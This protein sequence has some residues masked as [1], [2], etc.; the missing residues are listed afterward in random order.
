MRTLGLLSVFLLIS[1]WG[2]VYGKTTNYDNNKEIENKVSTQIVI[3]DT[4]RTSLLN[5]TYSVLFNS[6]YDSIM[7]DYALRDAY[8]VAKPKLHKKR[9]RKSYEI[10]PDSSS[11]I[12][13]DLLAGDIFNDGG[14][15]L[16]LNRSLDE[17]N[18]SFELFRV[19]GNKLE[20]IVSHKLEYYQ[21]YFDYRYQIKDVNRDGKKDLLIYWLYSTCI[22]RD[23]CTV[24]LKM[25][26][27]STFSEKHEF[28]NPTFSFKEGVV[29]CYQHY[30]IEGGM[31]Y[32]YI[33]NGFEPN[34]VEY[35]YTDFENKGLYIRSDKAFSNYKDVKGES[36]KSLPKEYKRGKYYK[37][38]INNGTY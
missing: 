28:I 31:L 34:P 5:R 26:D 17:A 18:I 9:F 12:E 33:W 38:F 35:I 29:K 8:L 10:S 24:Y 16:L 11:Y 13:I 14:K 23:M 4:D 36:L 6:N 3:Y 2:Y 1:F 32:K 21:D 37:Q 22:D 27:I 7:F 19:D 15:Y 25:D 30:S 20:C